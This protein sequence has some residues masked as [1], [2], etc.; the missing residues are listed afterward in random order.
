MP[1]PIAVFAFNRPDHLRRTLEALSANRLAGDS[2]LTVF[3]DAPRGPKD[4]EVCERLDDEV[5]RAGGLLTTR[6]PAVVAEGDVVVVHELGAVMIKLLV[7]CFE[8]AKY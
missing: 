1:A 2:R 7:A 5:A 8:Q 6:Q 4:V 3:C